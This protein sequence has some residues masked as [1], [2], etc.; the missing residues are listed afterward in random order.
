MKRLALVFL[1]IIPSLHSVSAQTFQAGFY[2]GATMTDI[3]GTDNIDN[4]VDFEH[5]GFVVAGTVCAQI[6]PKTKLQMEIRF[7]QKGA[8]QNPQYTNDSAQ[9]ATTN[10]SG[11]YVNQYFTL[12]LDYVDVTMGIKHQIHF[13]LR[14]KGTD[15]YGIE[16]GI[17]VGALVH[18][19]YSVESLNYPIDINTLDF[20]PYIG[21]YYNV[22]PHFYIEGRY[23]N[24][25]N[26]SVVADNTN[27]GSFYNLYYGTFNDGHNVAFSLT[28]GFIFGGSNQPLDNSPEKKPAP[29]TDSTDN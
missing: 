7:I 25:I 15:R 17:S 27:Q 1:F 4:D 5:L 29:S 8:Q 18:Y 6:S 2:G 28:L 12:V 23:A 14:N 21:I 16:A 19:T 11:Q 10:T 24:S 22:T 3:P 20:S 26:S 13:N 9:T